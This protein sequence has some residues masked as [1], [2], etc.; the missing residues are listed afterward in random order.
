[1]ARAAQDNIASVSKAQRASPPPKAEPKKSA[2]EEPLSPR[3]R[4]NQIKA[5]A[6]E[7]AEAR[8]R[9]AAVVAAAAAE[10][11]AAEAEAEAA[12]AEGI[13]N[14]KT[15]T[16]AAKRYQEADK[17]ALGKAVDEA[18]AA[19]AAAVAAAIAAVQRD[20]K[21]AREVVAAAEEAMERELEAARAAAGFALGDELRAF[22]LKKEEKL[23]EATAAADEALDGLDESEDEDE[24]ERGESVKPRVLM[25]V[26]PSDLK[27]SPLDFKHP[28]RAEPFAASPVSFSICELH[29]YSSLSH[30]DS[31]CHRRLWAT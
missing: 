7:A 6:A 31:L 5:K 25:L 3:T 17:D 10:A 16:I 2:A 21:E 1:M 24:E 22:R 26:P 14:A 18:D 13:A 11:E 19:E 20:R 23:D 27:G 8:A 12:A 29:S 30:C 28:V 15:A 9:E 4:R